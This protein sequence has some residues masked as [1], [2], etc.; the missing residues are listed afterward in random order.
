MKK[1]PVFDVLDR[2]D[3]RRVKGGGRSLAIIPCGAACAAGDACDRRCECRRYS[4]TR[5]FCMPWV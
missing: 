4:P 5:A 2:H 3:L 1:L